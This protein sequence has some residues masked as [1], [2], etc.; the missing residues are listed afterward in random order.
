MEVWKPIP[1]VNG[2]YEASS[3]GRIRRLYNNGNDGWRV[4]KS[5][6]HNYYEVI[7]ISVGSRATGRRYQ[8]GDH[9]R[10]SS[11][12][13]KVHRLVLEAFVGYCPNGMMTRHLNGN[14]TD[15][16]IENLKWGSWKKN[17]EDMKRHG[18]RRGSNNG[19]TKLTE[20]DIRDIRKLSEEMTNAAIAERYG[21]TGTAIGYIVNGK[22]WTHVQ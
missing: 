18:T 2:E 3:L 16:R 12:Q 11:K 7:S 1:R 9:V 15:N 21:V 17:C 6:V 5:L 19:R 13:F 8:V 10:G 14:S 22:T 20:D 4:M